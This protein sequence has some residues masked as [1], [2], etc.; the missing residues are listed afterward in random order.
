VPII[1]DG[2]N[3]VHDSWRIATYIDDRFP[4][5]PPLFGDE[6]ARSTA[7]FVNQ[8][9]DAVL[10]PALRRLICP[11]F[12]W[13]LAPEDHADF[14]SSREKAFGQWFS[15]AGTDFDKDFGVTADEGETF[16]L[17]VFLW[18]GGQCLPDLLH[19]RSWHRSAGQRLDVPRPPFET[20]RDTHQIGREPSRR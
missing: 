3:T 18:A 5:K 10:N 19:S 20:S 8:W 9:S 11:D 4:N 15:S 17:G 12:I 2:A 13:C 6:V 1:V 14:R 7:R 16:G